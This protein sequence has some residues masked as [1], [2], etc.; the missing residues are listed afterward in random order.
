MIF[1]SKKIFTL[2]FCIFSYASFALSPEEHLPNQAQE[3]RA[4]KLFSEVK[5]LVCAGQSV[6]GSSTEFSF[7]M[8]KLIRTKI[9][10]N[11]SND[12]IRNELVNEFG[13]EILLS[14]QSKI[15]WILPLIFAILLAAFLFTKKRGIIKKVDN[16]SP[17]PPSLF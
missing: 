8:R 3:Q 9:S 10:Q 16:I 17:S 15:L 14:N 7:E 11:K 6:E 4:L 2:I 1:T 13:D 12:E 5:C